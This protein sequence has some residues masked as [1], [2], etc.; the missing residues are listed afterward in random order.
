MIVGGDDVSY[1]I[2]LPGGQTY[3]RKLLDELGPRLDSARVHFLGW[4][5]SKPT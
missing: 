4:A 1:G 2:H 3:R 5:P